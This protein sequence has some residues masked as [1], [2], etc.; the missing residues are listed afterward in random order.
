MNNRHLLLRLEAASPAQLPG[1]QTASLG[2]RGPGLPAASFSGADP[3]MGSTLTPS[4]LPKAH[5]PT[6]SLPG[7]QPNHLGGLGL[8]MNL[9]DTPT[10]SSTSLCPGPVGRH[11]AHF[12]DGRVQGHSTL[13]AGPSRQDICTEVLPPSHLGVSSCCHEAAQAP[14]SPVPRSVCPAL[15]RVQAACP[16]CTPRRRCPRRPPDPQPLQSRR[17]QLL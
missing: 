12:M 11:P 6:A 14:S 10:D 17:Q 7:A 15:T 3:S 13:G 9:G 2:T 1:P 16:P 5:L 8:S 4:H